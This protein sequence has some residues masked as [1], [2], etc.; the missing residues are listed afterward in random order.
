MKQIPQFILVNI[1]LIA[2]LGAQNP[3]SRVID[4]RWESFQ[5][6]LMVRAMEERASQVEKEIAE[7]R[8]AQ[9]LERQFVAKMNRFI[10]L[11]K[12]LAEDYNVKSAFNVKLAREVAKAFHDL[13]NGEGWPKTRK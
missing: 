5:H 7:R 11:W 4:E 2:S 3:Q 1:C 6:E 13:E 9:Y 12:A 8:Y 10:L